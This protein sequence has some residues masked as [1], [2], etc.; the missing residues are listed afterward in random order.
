MTMS[1]TETKFDVVIVGAGLSGIG[2][3]Y[4]LQKNCPSKKFIILEGRSTIGGTWDL[5]QYPGNL[6]VDYQFFI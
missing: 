1:E 4:N 3:A 6:N 5:F 2:A